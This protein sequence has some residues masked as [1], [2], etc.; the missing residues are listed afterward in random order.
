MAGTNEKP[1]PP[2]SAYQFKTNLFDIEK[3]TE[4]G[5]KR[6]FTGVA[7]SGEVIQGHYYWGDVIFDLDT[8]QMKTPLGALID[9]DTGRR[10]GVVRNFTKDNQGGLKVSG[11]L[12]SNKN[13]QEV[14]QDSDEG[15]PWEM[16]VY[17]VP[18]SI[19]EVDRGEV[20][21]N[22]KTLKAPITI[23]RNGVI[24]EVSFCALGADDNTSAVAASHTPKQFNKQ[25][26]TDV[27]EL[28]KEKAARIEAEQQ[29]DAA[30]NELKQFK[31]TKRTEDIATLEAELKTQFSAEDKTAYTAMDDTTF[32]FASKQLRQFSAGGQGGQQTP[33]TTPANQPNPALAHLFTHQ[34]NGGQ[35]GTGQA[36][37]STLDQAFNQ[38][39]AA[40]K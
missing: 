22:G 3:A 24:R 4:E 34:A 23:F 21:V 15:Y 32:A 7:Y 20:E 5:K 1:D 16:S 14:A 38:F 17:I 6:T 40:Q 12:L 13:G 36:Q 27:T 30:Q 37:G 31:E 39:A 25:E 18:G 2:I 33:A 28:E 10:A 29:R 26:D 11:D 19:E 9:H 35:A 8:I